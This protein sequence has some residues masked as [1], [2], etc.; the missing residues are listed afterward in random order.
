[1]SGINVKEINKELGKDTKNNKISSPNK[2]GESNPNNVVP[3]S[4]TNDKTSPTT[5]ITT[6]STPSPTN[7]KTETTRTTNDTTETTNSTTDT[8]NK[9]SKKSKKSKRK[10]KRKKE[11]T[12]EVKPENKKENAE[13]NS[14]A[15]ENSGN[16]GKSGPI[17]KN[18][19]ANSKLTPEQEMEMTPYQAARYQDSLTPSDKYIV[20][21][22][23][24][25]KKKGVLIQSKY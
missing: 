3:T 20:D 6:P 14:N 2:I 11:P 5:D 24:F 1:M 15:G 23:N 7:N 19:T 10:K 25:Q 17:C 13:E 12:N 22:G 16:N 9:N 4:P 18:L 21:T 8:T